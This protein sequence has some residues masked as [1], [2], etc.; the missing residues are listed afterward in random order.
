MPGGIGL[1]ELIFLTLLCTP[2]FGGVIVIGIVLVKKARK[3]SGQ[4][5]ESRLQQRVA[6]DD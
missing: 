5:D 2:L 4:S 6:S 1:I 3:N